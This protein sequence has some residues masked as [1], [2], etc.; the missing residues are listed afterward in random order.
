MVQVS[1]KKFKEL[2]K[3]DGAKLTIV[4]TPLGKIFIVNV[5]DTEYCY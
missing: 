5:N 4:N 1:K 3:S 2:L